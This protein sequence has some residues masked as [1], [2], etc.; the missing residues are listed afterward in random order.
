M[1]PRGR[2]YAED[3]SFLKEHSPGPFKI[4][5]TSPTW[6]LRQYRRGISDAAYPTPAEALVDLVDI[7]RNEVKA[8][9]A[10]GAPYI[11]L[12]SIRYVF[13]FTDERRRQEWRQM[14]VDPDDAVQQTLAADNAVLDGVPREGVTFGLHMC[15]GNNRS[16]YFAEGSYDRIA[17]EVFPSLN[18]D[19]FL[20]E[21]DTDRAGGFSPL[22]FVLRGKMVVLGLISTK[23]R[24]LESQDDL[25][26]RIEEASHYVP[27]EHLALSPQCG[28]AS[29]LQG[30]AIGWDDQRR[31]L[32]LLVDTARQAWG[33]GS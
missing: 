20:L 11:Q 9:A 18:Y 5:L 26:R 15:R 23:V 8:L 12:D 3:S 4:T 22:R 32:D 7:T 16:N 6:Y 29:V 17:E 31:K 13:D 28:F 24:E 10:E 14:G 21:Y 33:S 30:N 1:R 19:R 27:M 25:L 2:I